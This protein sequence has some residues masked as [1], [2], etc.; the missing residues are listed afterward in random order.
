[1]TRRR[2]VALVSAAVLVTLGLVAVVTIFLVTHTSVGREKLRRDFLQPLI[3]RAV[4]GSVY[5]G[6]LTGNMLTSVTIDT[7]A[8]RDSRGVLFLST[9]P[10]SLSYNPRDLL[11]N[12][13]YVHRAIVEHPYVHLIQ[14]ENGEWN[15]KEI[16]ASKRPHLP[17]PK[18]LQTR[19][20][21][22]YIVADS[23]RLRAGTFILSIPW[24]PDDSLH[25]ARRDSA[26]RAHLAGASKDVTQTYD[27]YSRTYTWTSLHGLVRHARL[28]DPDSDRKFGQQFVVDTLSVVEH[29]PPFR[30][31]NLST[32]VRRLGDSVWLDVRHFDLPASTGS[33][34]GKVVWGSD[35]PVRY[36]I[37][38][39]GDSVAL[40]DVSW[41]YPTLPRTGSG[42]VDLSIRSDSKDPSIINYGLAR[43]DMRS[44][45]SHLTGDMTFGV[46]APVLLVH[47][48]NLHADPVDFDLLRTLAGKPFPEDWQGQVYGTV[49]GRGGPLTHFIVDQSQLAFHDAHVH[50][51]VSTISGRG[52]LDIL[53]PAS[54]VFHG[55]DAQ[56]GSLDLRTIEYLFPSFPRLRG[57]ISG[58]ATL[59]SSWLDV[60]FSNADIVH[61]DGPGTPTE[62]TGSGRV[63]DGEPFITY[64]VTLNAQPLSLTALARSYPA[65][66]LRGLVSGPIRA[67]GSSPDLEL[68]TSLAG[69]AGA[70]SFDGH[71]DIDSIGG[72]AA[73][74]RGDFSNLGLAALLERPAVPVAPLSGH[75]DVDVSGASARS[76]RGSADL[77]I[78]RTRLDSILVYP[79]HASVRFADG[80]MLVDSLRLH[81]KPAM[82]V[83]SGGIG[84]PGGRPDSLRYTISIDSLGGFRPY[85]SHADTSISG[86]PLPADSLSGSVTLDG[87]ASGTLDSLDLAGH[88]LANGLVMSTKRV[89]SASGAFD[90]RDLLRAPNGTMDLRLDS[91]VVAGVALDSA[92]ARVQVEDQQHARFTA[93]ALSH[94]GP[95]IAAAGRWSIAGGTHA[96]RLDSL[97]ITVADRL[98]HLAGPADLAFDNA[99]VRLDSLVLR[100]QDSAVVALAGN[101]PNTGAASGR[102]RILRLPLG[103]FSTL[104]QTAQPITGFGDLTAIVSGTKQDPQIVAS[105]T[106]SGI[107]WDKVDIDD[108]TSTARYSDDRLNASLNVARR[109][110]TALSATASLPL[111]MTL[112]STRLLGDTLSA[113]VRADSTDVSVLGPLFAGAATGVRGRLSADVRA[114]GTWRHPAFAGF[115]SLLDGAAT[116]DA[117]GVTATKVN[118]RLD[119]LVD[120]R[121]GVDSIHVQLRASSEGEPAADSASLTGVLK[122]I[123]HANA[124]RSVD[125]SLAASSF[126]AL[127]KRSLADLYLS[128]TR[129]DFAAI[130]PLRLTG[131][132]SAPVLRGNL[133]VDRGSIFLQDRDLAR[134]QAVELFA[135]TTTDVTAPAE[136]T[137]LAQL[138][139]K[140]QIDNVNV[141]LGEDVRLRSTEAD[142][143]LGGQLTLLTSSSPAARSI[144][145]A[146]TLPGLALEGQLKTNGGTFNFD[147]GL[148]QREFQVLPNGV[149]TFDGS[150][151]NPIL[152]IKAQYNVKQGRQRDLG[153]IVNLHGRV[154]N[155]VVSLSSNAD[156]E[157]STSDLVSYLLTGKPGLDFGANSQTSQ[158][159]AS[160]LAPT[161]SAVAAD[162]LRQSLGSWV[163]AFQIQLGSG[164]SPTGGNGN[165]SS[166]QQYLQG[167]TI[168]AEKQVTNN[169]FLSVNTG[170]CQFGD[171]QSKFNPLSSLGAKIEYRFAPTTSLQLGSE[172]ESSKR[173]CSGEQSF[174]GLYNTPQ[175]F[176]LSLSRT[177]RF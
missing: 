121:R 118:G 106:L 2:L 52:E 12:R 150:P 156:Y 128:T 71:I 48:V 173:F 157:I 77:S 155:Q 74:G 175:Q 138:M 98:W 171:P 110:Q 172:P 66:P 133:R 79:S 31:R 163:D 40:D 67:R 153:V 96:V 17:T 50:G 41:V 59:D 45:E 149:V 42:S 167:A 160:V 113:A 116:I 109:G 24:H 174:T 164:D 120:E 57:T 34:S 114:S 169:I 68:A 9:G 140:L 46:G 70:F 82:I 72:Y 8:I 142:V 101:V 166:F 159:L 23:A 141:A 145:S 126:H 168:G 131:P 21:G 104:A 107:K 89:A 134:K 75:Y 13:I 44:T 152:D 83:A 84:L 1:M 129:G 38:V 78:E 161:I 69:P 111:E 61:H 51:A 25:G 10:V 3:A 64:D 103:D 139:S 93:G 56:I 87:V 86:E 5:L 162:Q 105:A 143:R 102:F 94:N 39:H 146:G 55:F 30:F 76:L 14:H 144:A 32:N 151:E 81:T 112:F 73:R 19:N 177:W 136:P 65:L 115:I 49:K 97:G 33:A 154:P 29:D 88:L 80:R 95:S 130:S 147:L 58:T 18:D 16:F 15:Y 4:H 137:R 135:D 85:L 27:G 47:D 36:D 124:A 22:D 26:I 91:L 108:I 117:A 7:I 100:N 132:L 148:V 63:T 170:F 122:N 54:T 60:R 6:H 165:Q 92:G 158:V 11:D 99:G 125:L 119:G 20:L 90:L 43:M 62:V 37:A 123:G 35:L 127:D 53:Q 28:A 176:S